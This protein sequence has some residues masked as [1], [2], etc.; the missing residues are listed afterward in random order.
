[1]GV[2]QFFPIVGVQNYQGDP[3]LQ[4]NS[5]KYMMLKQPKFLDK[6]KKVDILG[7]WGV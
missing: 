7:G 4:I 5:D 3:Q 1:M 6:V 2:G